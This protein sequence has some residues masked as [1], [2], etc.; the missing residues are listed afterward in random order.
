ML[1]G[2][3]YLAN[4]KKEILS[5]YEHIYPLERFRPLKHGPITAGLIM[6]PFGLSS[7]SLFP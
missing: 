1:L 7:V 4:V 6:T 5:R 2:W 3:E